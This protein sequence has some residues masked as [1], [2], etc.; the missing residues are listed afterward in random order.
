LTG[1]PGTPSLLREINDRAALELL[2]A[3]GA[4][5]RSQ[6]GERTGLSKVTASQTLTRL[7]ERGLVTVTGQQ[8][9]GRGPSAAI[10]SVVS[11]SAYVAALDVAPEAVTTG[12]ADVT[13]RLLTEVAVDPNGARNPVQLVRNAVSTACRSAQVEVEQLRAFVIGTGGMVDARTGDVRL[14]VDMPDWHEGVLDALRNDLRRPVTIENDVNLAAMAEHALGAA[15]GVDDF[16]LVWLGVGL[17]LATILGGRL[18][19]GARGAAGEIGYLPVPGVPLPEDLT[20]PASGGF[21]SL[22]DG[23]QVRLLAE[24][25]GFSLSPADRVAG[26]PVAGQRPTAV[27]TA[28]ESVAAAVAAAESGDPNAD[29]FLADLA[30]RVAVGVASVVVTLDPELVVLGGEVGQAGG[31]ALAA[32]VSAE[33]GRIC[34]VT[35]DVVPTAVPDAPVLRGALLAAVDQARTGLLAS[36]ADAWPGHVPA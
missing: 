22:A 33:V 27:V 11:S 21:R 12:V 18:H 31:D 34:P 25:Y 20:H 24:Q 1:R 10:Y 3:E 15:Q 6:V 26:E 19:R 13:G 36:V 16:V 17:G 32:Q 8:A 5:T 28:G 23:R 2:L 29:A 9:G 35:P 7:Q 14:F 30:R 4:L